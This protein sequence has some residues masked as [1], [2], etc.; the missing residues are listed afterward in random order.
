MP[1]GGVAEAV[2]DASLWFE[3]GPDGLSPLIDAV[4][5]ARLVLIGEASHGTDEFYRVRADLTAAL[6]HKKSFNIV[7]AEADW[8][9]AYRANRWVR[10]ASEDPDPASALGDFTRFPR[11][12]WRNDVVVEFLAWLRA[13]NANREF[14]DR[15]GFYGLDLYSLHTSMDAVLHYLDK[16]DPDGARRAREGYACFEGLGSDPQSYGYAATL[17][18]SRTCEDDVVAQLVELRKPRGGIREPRRLCGRGRILLRRTE[19]A[20]G[21][22][23]GAVLP[24]DVPRRSRGFLEPPR[25][26]HDGA[27]GRAHRVDTPPIRRRESHCLG[28]QL[29][30]G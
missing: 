19:C 29:A 9:D 10:L 18:L 28:A 1:G 26:P 13:H 30:P 4:G 8:P 22:Q 2:R 24:L 6:I 7:A 3:F 14:R 11:W 20:A 27:A 21:A 12:M 23:R 5:D 17:G 16:V 15:V 25:H